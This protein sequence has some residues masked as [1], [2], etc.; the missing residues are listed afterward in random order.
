MSGKQVNFWVQNLDGEDIPIQEFREELYAVMQKYGVTKLQ[1]YAQ[2]DERFGTADDGDVVV[3]CYTDLE[4]CQPVPEALTTGPGL[5]A[6][7]W[8]LVKAYQDLA[9]RGDSDTFNAIRQN[10]MQ[11]ESEH[12]I[13][14]DWQRLF[15]YLWNLAQAD[16]MPIPQLPAGYAI[17]EIAGRRLSVPPEEV[18]RLFTI[19]RAARRLLQEGL[20]TKCSQACVDLTVAVHDMT[21][22]REENTPKRDA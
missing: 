1:A 7:M 3:N 20:H 6:T 9:L 11:P 13:A 4:E 15:D 17:V 5:R 14:F 16:R 12:V 10:I 2:F 22:Y 8:G 19:E 21:I 18:A